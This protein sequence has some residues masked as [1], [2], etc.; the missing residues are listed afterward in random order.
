MARSLLEVP[1]KMARKLYVQAFECMSST[2]DQE[3]EYS[4]T[5]LA[6]RSTSTLNR[7]FQAKQRSLVVAPKN[8]FNL[9][10]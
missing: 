6:K 5:F 3:A 10:H 2:P 7:L 8:R 9:V 4:W 1:W